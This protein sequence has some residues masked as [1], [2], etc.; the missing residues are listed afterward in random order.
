MGSGVT[1]FL[2]TL[3]YN[4]SNQEMSFTGRVG[5][6]DVSVKMP[7]AANS[8]VPTVLSMSYAAASGSAGASFGDVLGQVPLLGGLVQESGVTSILGPFDLPDILVTSFKVNYESV[9]GSTADMSMSGSFRAGGQ[10]MSLTWTGRTLESGAVVT[11]TFSVSAAR[12]GSVS[13]S[14]TAQGVCGSG[15][16]AGSG[17]F[18]LSLQGLPYGLPDFPT[19]NGDVTFT[20]D[21]RKVKAWTVEVPLGSATAPV[22]VPVLGQ[23]TLSDIKAR[24]ASNSTD[25]RLSAVL[26][27]LE[28]SIEAP[29][30]DF[31]NGLRTAI[32]KPPH[33]PAI[34]AQQV[35]QVIGP[36]ANALMSGAGLSAAVAAINAPAGRRLQQSVPDVAFRELTVFFPQ[37]G[38]SVVVEAAMDAQGLSVDVTTTFLVQGNDFIVQTFALSLAYAGVDYPWSLQVIG[39]GVPCSPGVSAGAFEVS[40]DF[41]S[42]PHGLGAV[43]PTNGTASFTCTGGDVTAWNAKMFFEDGFLPVS[44][45]G[46]PLT[47]LGVGVGVAPGARSASVFGTIEGAFSLALDLPG[48]TA[49]TDIFRF[50]SLWDANRGISMGTLVDK[51]G[52]DGFGGA[53]RDLGVSTVAADLSTVVVRKVN[54]DASPRGFTAQLDFQALDLSLALDMRT[55]QTAPGTH[56]LQGMSIEVSHPNMIV[57]FSALDPCGSQDVT[58]PGTATFSGLPE[59]VTAVGPVEATVT[60]TCTGTTVTDYKV[61]VPVGAQMT[62]DAAGTPVTVGAK[63]LTFWAKSKTVRL[64]ALL[65]RADLLDK[66]DVGL[67]Y[68]IGDTRSAGAVDIIVMKP[69]SLGDLMDA[70]PTMS[71]VSSFTSGVNL[72]QPF[73]TM[74]EEILALAV[75]SGRVL[76]VSPK[77]VGD[78]Q[79]KAGMVFAGT[80]RVFSRDV[81]GWFDITKGRDGSWQ[82]LVAVA[83]EAIA[84]HG[85][86]IIQRVLDLFPLRDTYVGV[87]T[88]SGTFRKFDARNPAAPMEL[89]SFMEASSVMVT[90]KPD[91]DRGPLKEIVGSGSGAIGQ[92]VAGGGRVYVSFSSGSYV[93]EMALPADIQIGPA[94][95]R[96]LSLAVSGGQ[97]G[98][99]T[100]GFGVSMRIRLSDANIDFAGQMSLD[101]ATSTLAG[102]VLLTTAQG[103]NDPMGISSELT[104]RTFGVDLRMNV[105][106]NQILRFRGDASGDWGVRSFRNPTQVSVAYATDIEFPTKTAFY[107]EATDIDLYRAVKPI[108]T[109]LGGRVPSAAGTLLKS[110]SMSRYMLSYNPSIFS[111]RTPNRLIPAGVNF[112]ARNVRVFG[113]AIGSAYFTTTVGLRP[114]MSGR[115]DM[116]PLVVGNV[117]KVY[118][119]R[120]N[121]RSGPRCTLDFQ[122]GRNP[123]LSCSG[124][125]SIAG[126]SGDVTVLAKGSSWTYS[127]RLVLAFGSRRQRAVLALPGDGGVAGDAH[128]LVPAVPE[129]AGGEG[130][131]EVAGYDWASEQQSYK[132]T[133]EELEELY[134][135]ARGDDLMQ[136]ASRGR[137][138]KRLRVSGNFWRKVDTLNSRVSSSRRYSRSPRNNIYL[139]MTASISDLSPRAVTGGRVTVSY[140]FFVSAS[141]GQG[142][143]LVNAIVNGLADQLIRYVEQIKRHA[144]AAARQAVSVA[145]RPLKSAL[146]SAERGLAY[147]R[148]RLFSV[149]RW[150]RQRVNRL[151]RSENRARRK[152]R[153]YR[154]KCS[155]YKPWHCTSKAWWWM[156]WKAIKGLRW[157][158]NRALRLAE[159]G[160]KRA[161]NAARWV[162]N[163]ARSALRRMQQAC[164]RFISSTLNAAAG[165]VNQIINAA[166]S[167][168]DAV[169]RLFNVDWLRATATTSGAL[170]GR[171]DAE[172]RVNPFSQGWK[173]RR[174][175]CRLELLDLSTCIFTLYAREVG[176]WF[177]R[178]LPFKS[179]RSRQLLSAP[180]GLTFEEEMAFLE[181]QYRGL[182]ALDASEEVSITDWAQTWPGQDAAL[183]LS[184]PSRALLQ[185]AV[186]ANLTVTD[187]DID[188]EEVSV[189]NVP[190]VTAVEEEPLPA[191]H[192]QFLAAGND[193]DIQVEPLEK[194]AL[195]K[196]NNPTAV[197]SDATKSLEEQGTRGPNGTVEPPSPAVLRVQAQKQLS[198]RVILEISALNTTAV[199]Q[200]QKQVF[201]EEARLP[202]NL[203]D[204]NGT[205]VDGATSPPP[206]AATTSPASGERRGRRLRVADF[207]RRLEEAK[208]DAAGQVTNAVA[209]LLKGSVNGTEPEVIDPDLDWTPAGW[210][211]NM[212]LTVTS[213]M[214]SWREIKVTDPDAAF[215]RIDIKN[216]IESESDHYMKLL[217]KPDAKEKM[218]A[219]LMGLVPKTDV[220]A[221]LQSI[222]VLAEGSDLIVNEDCPADRVN[223]PSEVYFQWDPLPWG[224]CNATCGSGTKQT[225][226]ISCSI[227]VYVEE[228]G[229]HVRLREAEEEASCYGLPV[230]F[231]RERLCQLPPCEDATLTPSG[232]FTECTRPCGG[233]TQ[234]A[235][236]KCRT[237]LGRELPLADCDFSY[238]LNATTQ[239]CNTESCPPFVYM[240]GPWGLCSQAC[241]G[242]MQRRAATCY[243]T[244]G[245]TPAAGGAAACG[246]APQIELERPCN[247]Q[248]CATA[249]W[250]VGPWGECDRNCTSFLPAAFGGK[251]QQGSHSREVWCAD[252]DGSRVSETRCVG[253]RPSTEEPCNLQLC[254]G[255]SYCTEVKCQNDGVCRDAD[256]ERG[257]ECECPADED[258]ELL[259]KGP[260][261]ETPA[262]CN[263]TIASQADGTTFCCES[264]RLTPTGGC[265][266][267]GNDAVDRNGDCC[268]AGSLDGC[269]VCFGTGTGFDDF[270]T[271]CAAGKGSDG[272]CCPAGTAPDECGVCG[273][274]NLL[275]DLEVPVVLK[276]SES[277]I[278][279]DLPSLLSATTG[280]V[281]GVLEVR[282]AR[283]TTKAGTE[284]RNTAEQTLSVTLILRHPTQNGDAALSSPGAHAALRAAGN[285]ISATFRRVA[286][287]RRALRGSGEDDGVDEQLVMLEPGAA[288]AWGDRL[289]GFLNPRSLVSVQVAAAAVIG[290]VGTLTSCGNGVCDSS[291]ERLVI[292]TDGVIGGCAWEPS[293]GAGVGLDCPQ[294]VYACPSPSWA[295]SQPCGAKGTCVGFPD[296]GVT[297]RA[298]EPEEMRHK[299]VCACQGPFVGPACGSCAD[300]YT[301]IAGSRDNGNLL[302][303][304]LE[305]T[306][307]TVTNAT[308][309][310]PDY[311]DLAP[312][313]QA[314]V[315]WILVTAMIAVPVFCFF[316]MW[317]LSVQSLSWCQ[318]YMAQHAKIFVRQPTTKKG[319]SDG[320]KA[321]P[322]KGPST[323][324]GFVVSNSRLHAP[325]LI[326]ARLTYNVAKG[327]SK[328]TVLDDT[329]GYIPAGSLAAL[330]GPSGAGKT[331]LLRALCG[332]TTK[333]ELTGTRL[334]F[335]QSATLSEPSQ[336]LPDTWLRSNCKFVSQ[337]DGMLLDNLTAL[338][339]LLYYAD[340]ALPKQMPREKRMERVRRVLADVGLTDH[341]DVPVRHDESARGAGGLSGGQMRRLSLA[342]ALLCDPP[343]LFCDEPTSG[344]DA[345]SALDVCM[346]LKDLTLAQDRTIIVS[347]HQPREDIFSLFDQCVLMGGG[348]QTVYC[349]PS[350][351]AVTDLRDML[352]EA[353]DDD[354]SW[355]RLSQKLSMADFLMDAMN[356]SS[357][358]GVW[359][360]HRHATSVRQSICDIAETHLLAS[361]SLA[362]KAGKQA[363]D[364][365][366]S[367]R[368]GVH[369]S[370]TLANLRVQ[371]GR[372]MASRSL[373][374]Q[375]SLT[376]NGAVMGLLLGLL[377]LR[378]GTSDAQE[379]TYRLNVSFFLTLSM[380]FG[381]LVQHTS[382][383]LPAEMARDR[384]E[385]ST[386]GLP[387]HSLQSFLAV[388]DPTMTLGASIVAHGITYAL[389]GFQPAF[390]AYCMSLLAFYLGMLAIQSAYV[391]MYGLLGA[392]WALVACGS[393]IGINGLFSG[394]LRA[395]PDM[396]AFLGEWLPYVTPLL[397]AMRAVAAAELRGLETDACNRP[398]PEMN[399]LIQAVVNNDQSVLRAEP[400]IKGEDILERAGYGGTDVF[401]CFGILASWIVIA[402]L[403]FL[404][405]TY[406]R[407]RVVARTDLNSQVVVLEGGEDT[408]AEEAAKTIQ[409]YFRMRKL[410]QT[411][412]E[413]TGR[414]EAV[415]RLH[416]AKAGFYRK[417]FAK[418]R[419]VGAARAFARS[420]ATSRATSA[421]P[422]PRRSLA[423][424]EDTDGAVSEHHIQVTN[425]LAAGLSSMQQR[426]VGFAPDAD[427]DESPADSGLL[428]VPG[429]LAMAAQAAVGRA[430]FGR[431]PA[432]SRLANATTSEYD[433]P[434]GSVAHSAREEA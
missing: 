339:T 10:T 44:G 365:A 242:G 165:G 70:V 216:V 54:I 157:A 17:T 163:R 353:T 398:T 300:G 411:V 22:D 288:A 321:S 394:V 276:I 39:S 270:G 57:K 357:I 375:L 101:P 313:A 151:R 139:D 129:D 226:G 363:G 42:L 344:L 121:T 301:E 106:T 212:T 11:D 429:R 16:G 241:G 279:N 201:G 190:G 280:W 29:L 250:M 132:W 123:E 15:V 63:D 391:L 295:P 283:V 257:W 322:R 21:G 403:L 126:V 193:T 345:T 397:W 206:P 393:F 102:R 299:A 142:R 92:Q 296:A 420:R 221:E 255:E 71:V 348:G 232:D 248:A 379:L 141:S 291:A 422:S 167:G 244:A 33:L 246:G 3:G 358:L 130:D 278:S 181:L 259:W 284:V 327:A 45:L 56:I 196:A 336:Y 18:S 238:A 223:A 351:E 266:P 267:V 269:N 145:L 98:T 417:A 35:I 188:G 30:S 307:F 6:V 396:P 388:R 97:T 416:R 1:V 281:A 218:T 46:I 131:F 195:D 109:S 49:S 374:V 311:T 83:A 325:D 48:S 263:G 170:T 86:P 219:W 138:L 342:V 434:L 381:L 362:A 161:I 84:G 137:G 67:T 304:P 41:S 204:V 425:N 175:S 122:A 364:D 14:V 147:A 80:V 112:D 76:F 4:T 115:I 273:G 324:T 66:L 205:Q 178:L 5:S 13:M 412:H 68:I 418:K 350:V 156:K 405:L 271:C 225:R 104:I 355:Q 37:D 55:A 329:Y 52:R 82:G 197:F 402:R 31:K 111:V 237:T 318:R 316:A 135:I 164:N 384:L 136:E 38:S 187:E 390:R 377:Y 36:S 294:P 150:M 217:S 352:M 77:G 90:G 20:C 100:V 230:T 227:M 65:P 312:G 88:G 234:T 127:M 50:T 96:S 367:P 243:E 173:T 9:P 27:P 338:E 258:G 51:L 302:C 277:V 319:S 330:M 146:R 378:L 183:R 203:D 431:M 198:I 383:F 91:F 282:P 400:C 143:G 369:S 326:W 60:F 69:V 118:R 404:G 75:Q 43:V 171:V 59:P 231:A 252:P 424:G 134:S 120:G 354:K 229:G 26:S 176:Q 32:R 24:Y 168:G 87:A 320:G 89:L 8:S 192:E 40:A 260:Q 174:F 401:E 64:S 99:P 323:R 309:P 160:L 349:G 407:S 421:A 426:R 308:E 368:S 310:G 155:W 207:R 78:D 74:G 399:T 433:S 222:R 58:A 133:P 371:V 332:H 200:E 62:L 34:T 93:V 182:L 240:G 382:L 124:H 53:I 199:Q 169:R 236:M 107:V 341:A 395:I 85:P 209:A 386:L 28:I 149:T 210:M 376:L 314:F 347:I 370:G 81:E 228:V 245:F 337:G 385:R 410:R 185:A 117:F 211:S 414:Y 235:I 158:A 340:I 413:F 290:D 392:E 333:G 12:D 289:L 166:R 286:R 25:L 194:E 179:A 253:A 334:Y 224:P 154:R 293:F 409:Y 177:T 366:A 317:G 305:E 262:S 406:W 380:G 251:K 389:A 159:Y 356:D 153:R 428:Q 359:R 19:L 7:L 306:L 427:E 128:A 215:V 220:A 298:G 202:G 73:S 61:V 191:D 2:P 297:L 415:A 343:M 119:S 94:H 360:R 315:V 303:T 140:S 419:A 113:Q 285:T 110:V 23:V 116:A 114:R 239:P 331:Q 108:F 189:S 79:T 148:R 261:C 152:Y 214:L 256:N 247:V 361:R 105:A 125:T 172:V 47:G 184:R 274:R 430:I 144:I 103:W 423:M 95:V 272:R 346:L 249:R 162:V 254:V 72:Q 233:G 328:K 287:S 275:C 265:C 372:F 432:P 373:A 387:W 408:P 186:A 268:P 292:S 264:G 180:E 213:R 335:R 208:V